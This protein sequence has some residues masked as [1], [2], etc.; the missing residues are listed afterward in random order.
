VYSFAA[1]PNA[2][3]RKAALPDSR[4]LLIWAD[5]WGW[6]IPGGGG[7]AWLNWMRERW[8]LF[9]KIRLSARCGTG[10]L[11]GAGSR[12]LEVSLMVMGRRVKD[13]S[14]LCR[15]PEEFG[16]RWMIRWTCRY[17]FREDELIFKTVSL[18]FFGYYKSRIAPLS[19]R[20]YV[21]I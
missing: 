15:G 7:T 13:S 11:V 18:G 8:R 16:G 14:M 20:M 1:S 9:R 10:T 3:L 12:A 19:S 2:C 5:L 21:K 4:S 6:M 17:R